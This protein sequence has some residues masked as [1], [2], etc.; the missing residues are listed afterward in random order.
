MH[1]SVIT[2][3]T[4]LALLGCILEL[5]RRHQLREK[6]AALWLAV[7]SAVVPLGLFPQMLD[8][9]ARGLGIVSGASLVL[10]AGIVLLLLVCL[11]LSWESSRLEEETR[12]LAEEIALIRAALEEQNRPAAVAARRTEG[13]AG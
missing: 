3:L 6:Y 11:H 2:S 8:S 1:L 10:F 13:G 9:L 12:T 5:L 7:G 4:G